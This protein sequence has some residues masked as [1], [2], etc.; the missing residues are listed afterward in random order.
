[1]KETFYFSHDYGARNDE[2]ILKLIQKEGWTGYGI[3]WAIIEKLYEADGFLDEDYECIAFDLR[4]ECDRITR[5]IQDYKL[6]TIASKKIHSKSCLARLAVRKGISEQNRQNAVLRWN[7]Q[8]KDDATALR[9]QSEGNAS[10]VKES[11]GKESKVNKIVIS[12]PSSQVDIKPIMDIFYKINP[13]LNWGNK[14]QRKAVEEMIQKFGLE[15]TKGLA[16]YA[17]SIQGQPFSPTITTPYQLKE[18]ASALIAFYQK[19][20]NSNKPNI[21]SI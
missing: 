11:K 7:K 17:V 12:E 6:F 16:E 14:T 4:A 8:K 18:K 1:M 5:I 21:V 2:K 19:Q 13:T 9:P 20:N 15:K 3:Y 10:K